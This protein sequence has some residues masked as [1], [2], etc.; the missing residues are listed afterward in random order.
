MCSSW[1]PH[2][3]A[4]AM[5]TFA[6]RGQKCAKGG[7]AS[8]QVALGATAEGS[9]AHSDPCSLIHPAW[10]PSVLCLDWGQ[11]PWKLDLALS[12]GH[13]KV[14]QTLACCLFSCHWPF[15]VWDNHDGAVKTSFSKS[16]FTVASSVLTARFTQEAC[17][18]YFI[19]WARDLSHRGF[20]ALHIYLASLLSGEKAGLLDC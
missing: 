15:L 2:T 3:A 1:Q 16:C 6:P 11:S 7:G 9:T 14:L 10:L 4:E 18:L 17:L 13:W 19:A 5:V 8:V 20:S 12:F